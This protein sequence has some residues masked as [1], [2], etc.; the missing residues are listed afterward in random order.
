MEWQRLRRLRPVQNVLAPG[1]VTR[2][3]LIIENAKKINKQQTSVEENVPSGKENVR[4]SKRPLQ[5][6][7]GDELTIDNVKRQLFASTPRRD[8]RLV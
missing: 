6:G 1:T 5:H 8:D 4:P 7:I 2:T 3:Q